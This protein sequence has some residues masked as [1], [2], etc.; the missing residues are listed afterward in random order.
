MK[1]LKAERRAIP[2]A[3]RLPACRFI[4]DMEEDEDEIERKVMMVA[5]GDDC[6][7][8]G[9]CSRVCAKNCQSHAAA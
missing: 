3:L 8:C 7:G 9:A 6:I 4:L 1:A 5:K 2:R